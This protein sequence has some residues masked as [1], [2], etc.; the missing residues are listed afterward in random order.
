MAKRG[1]TLYI[2]EEPTIGLH[3]ADV[4]LLQGVLH[5]LVDEGHTVIV[6][7]HHLDLVAEADHIIDVGPEAGY[8]GGKIIATGTPEEVSKNKESRT[9]PF[10][11][12]VLGRKATKGV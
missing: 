8:R 3:A 10:L 12:E 4:E 5:R 7:E 9:A 6:V 1:G 11:K 2:L